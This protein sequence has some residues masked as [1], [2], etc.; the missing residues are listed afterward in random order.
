MNNVEGKIIILCPN[1]GKQVRVP[2][3]KNKICITCPSC[4]IKFD[5][6]YSIFYISKEVKQLMLFGF[7]GGFLGFISYE[8]LR[9]TLLDEIKLNIYKQ[10]ILTDGIFGALVGGFLGSAEGYFKNNKFRLRYGLKMGLL[11]G[12]VGGMISGFIAQFM[13]SMILNNITESTIVIQMAARTIGWAVWGM[14]LGI[15]Y[16]VKQNTLGDLKF[17]AIS[18]LIGGSIGGFLFDPICLF[19]GGIGQGSVARLVGFSILGASLGTAIQFLQES[20]IK[21][22]AKDMYTP[23]TKKLPT[24]LRLLE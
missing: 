11:L 9:V 5:H 1:C 4:S 19:V 24:N 21:H 2:R 23:L 7:F 13:Y 22:G 18:G 15:S 6:K 20:A 16:G 3:L 10:A 14:L 8:V 17:G 12:G